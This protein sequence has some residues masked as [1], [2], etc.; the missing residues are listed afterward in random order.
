MLSYV[1][2]IEHSSSMFTS[3][4][5]IRCCVVS[6]DEMPQE[7]VLSCIMPPSKLTDIDSFARLIFR[8]AISMFLSQIL[9]FAIWITEGSRIFLLRHQ[10]R[11]VKKL[12]VNHAHKDES[13]QKFHAVC[14]F[15]QARSHE[16]Y[17]VDI[18]QLSLT[19]WRL[20]RWDIHRSIFRQRENFRREKKSL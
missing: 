1:G 2:P 16:L 5:N 18:I 12:N 4:T 13:R 3:K 15:S 8:S 9:C 19:T 10:Q 17:G 7:N 14:R 11:R 6:W 20:T